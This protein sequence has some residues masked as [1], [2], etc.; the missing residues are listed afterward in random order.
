MHGAGPALLHSEIFEPH[1]SSQCHDVSVGSRCMIHQ[2]A[3]LE[4]VK[5]PIV[6]GEENVIE[7]GVIIQNELASELRIGRGNRFEVDSCVRGS[8]GD[9][10]VFK[11]RSQIE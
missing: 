1:S 11:T 7:E 5:G 4:A 2:S 3:R 9:Y 6:L 8:V 10:N